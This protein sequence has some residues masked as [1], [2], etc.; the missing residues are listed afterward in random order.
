[1]ADS[2]P[3]PTHILVLVASRDATSL[4]TADI[5]HARDLSGGA[6]PVT[7]SEGEAVEIPCPAPGTG[8]MPH[9]APLREEFSR[10][11]I[12]AIV[13]AA[14][15]R[16]KRLL[17]ADMDSTI[18]DCETLDDLAR[19]AGIG[20][21]IAEITRRS[22]NGEMDF[23]AALRE[24]VGL[25][26]GMSATLLEAAWKD[27]RLNPGAL[28]LVRTMRKHGAHTA[29]VSGGFTFFTSRVAEKCGFDEQH[30][31][32]LLIEEGHLTGKVGQPILGPDAK[33]AHLRRL[34][35][36]HGLH[37]GQAMAVGDGA[38]DL[39][40]LR[41]AG[42]G[43]AFHAKPAVRKEIAA[44]VNHTTLRTLL[45]AQGYAAADFVA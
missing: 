19:H 15:G 29:L 33:L 32:T 28:E 39:A 12:D 17:V 3:S 40:M 38:N 14:Q 42:L 30:A 41:E 26:R 23:E 24:R 4:G 7:L 31:N 22:M 9:I 43:I 2:S 34:V 16:R 11:H 35:Q 5:A 27:V 1:M 37:M 25:L 6:A 20:E 36:G 8:D 21:R 10:R 44:Q 13:V 18:V 45:F